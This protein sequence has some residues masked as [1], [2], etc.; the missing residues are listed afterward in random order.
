MAMAQYQNLVLISRYFCAISQFV[1]SLQLMSS[2]ALSAD[3]YISPSVW[4]KAKFAAFSFSA[5]FAHPSI[6]NSPI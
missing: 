3:K 6:D 5:A 4:L 2:L 1:C